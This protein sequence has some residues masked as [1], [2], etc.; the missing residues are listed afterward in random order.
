MREVASVAVIAEY[1]PFHQ[2]HLYHL[3]QTRAKVGKDALLLVILGAEIT[4]RGGFSCFDKFT[5]AKAALACGADL[6]VGLNAL[7]GAQSAP[8]FARGALKIAE[9]LRVDALSF[10][11]ESL[12]NEAFANV[13]ALNDAQMEEELARSLTQTLPYANT[14]ATLYANALGVDVRTLYE[15]NNILALEY[16]LAAKALCPAMRLLPIKRC[17]SAHN[18]NQITSAYASACALRTMLQHPETREEAFALLPD[19]AKEIF[20]SAPMKQD[21]PDRLLFCL[22]ASKLLL[23][24]AGLSDTFEVTHDMIPSMRALALAKEPLTLQSAAQRLCN[25]RISKAR[26]RRALVN[27][28]FHITKQDVAFYQQAPL[29]FV[30]VLGFT[31]KGRALLTA[32]KQR[33]EGPLLLTNPKKQSALLSETQQRLYQIDRNVHDVYAGLFCPQC[34]NEAK[35]APHVLHTETDA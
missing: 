28:L 18:S 35:R 22:I 9:A 27:F 7:F 20:Y 11:C 26:A 21:L 25:K 16:A 3:A 34:T 2:G 24:P 15:P 10:G 13:M 32:L 8:V 12:T 23:D 5:R 19:R 29:P 30:R 14:K 31:Q 4:Q 1:D 17:G 6:V 33:G